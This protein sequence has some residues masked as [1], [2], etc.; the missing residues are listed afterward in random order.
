[1]QIRK[2]VGRRVQG[3]N[4]AGVQGRS[5]WE[6]QSKTALWRWIT[7]ARAHDPDQSTTWRL[8]PM[9]EGKEAWVLRQRLKLTV[10]ILLGCVGCDQASKM[11]AVAYLK[12]APPIH[13]LWDLV[14]LCYV[15]NTGSWGGLGSHLSEGARWVFF[16]VLPVLFLLVVCGMLLSR[17]PM[18]L[19]EVVC[20]SLI[21]AGGLGN[22]LDR[23]SQGHVIDFLYIGYAGI[24]TNIFNVADMA[25]LFGT[26]GLVAWLSWRGGE[27]PDATN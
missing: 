7:T 10:A 20:L 14:R 24:G 22:T 8:S 19:A 18:P 4:P 2:E 15:E 6:V 3:D 9:A 17:R 25:L 5:P 11:A 26:I 16:I 1:M 23:L 21:L 27:D 12:N 13:Y